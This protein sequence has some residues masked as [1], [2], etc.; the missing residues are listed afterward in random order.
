MSLTANGIE[1]STLAYNIE[2]LTGRLSVPPRRGKDV[3]V[4]GRHGTVRTPNK[5]YTSGTVVLPMWVVGS[6]D[7]WFPIGADSK[8]LLY[9][10]IDKLTRIFS[11]DTV[12]LIHTLPNGSSRKI[13]GQVVDAIDFTSQAGATR[14]TFAVSLSTSGAFWEDLDVITASKTGTGSWEVAEFHG[15]TA[16][17][18]DLTVKFTGPSTNP[19]ITNSSGVYVQYSAVLTGSQTIIIDCATWTLMGTAITPSLS[20]LIHVGDPRWFVLNPKESAPVATTS[21]TAGSTGVFVLIGRRKYL[22]G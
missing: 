11:S 22:V 4:P 6:D 21:Q 9:A 17:M 10:N 1:L 2:S 8:D 14:A 20:A 13:I 16:P 12:E 5:K 19:R 3:D 15:A 18:D 7:G